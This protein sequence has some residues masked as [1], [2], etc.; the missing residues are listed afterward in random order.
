M[1]LKATPKAMALAAAMAAAALTAPVATAIAQSE[2]AETEAKQSPTLELSVPEVD[3]GEV[4]D[5]EEYT[6]V[7]QLTNTGDAPLHVFELSSTC[8]CTVPKLGSTEV[9]EGKSRTVDQWI[10]PGE[11][12]DMSITLRTFGKR[13]DVNQKVTINS[14]DP[15]R[16]SLVLPVKAFVEPLV[17]IT[18]WVMD[19]GDIEKDGE[20]T[21]EAVVTT[22]LKDFNLRRVSFGTRVLRARKTSVEDIELDGR[23]VRRITLEVTLK[24]PADVGPLAIP[25]TM[26]TTS[27]ERA[28]VT[29]MTRAN[30]LGDLDLPRM[31]RFGVFSVGE[32]P[33]QTFRVSHRKG[34]DF[35]I[36]DIRADQT[37]IKWNAAPSEE[38]GYEVEIALL[39]DQPGSLRDKLTIETNVPGEEY[40]EVPIQG[41]ARVAGR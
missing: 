9:G 1:H 13:D 14:N 34:G 2:Q 8:G 37:E 16:P 33:E 35:K 28:L 23:Q 25:G 21:I 6:K 11:S 19:F 7:I 10:K 24:N 5:P 15:Q 41:I 39:R 38:G 4:R 32:T 17:R 18:P 26:R 40:I 12:I 30:V 36:L 20:K 29:L 31:L 22:P 27:E 3:F